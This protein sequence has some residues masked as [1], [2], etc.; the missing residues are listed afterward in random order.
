MLKTAIES[1]FIVPYNE[2]DQVKEMG[3]MKTYRYQ[4]HT[5]TSPCSAC[6][7]MTPAELIEGLHENGYQGCVMTNHFY[8]GNTGIDRGLPWKEF[9]GQYVKDY[10]K[11][12][13]YAQKYDLDILFGIEE[14]VGG[15]LEILCYGLTPQVLYDHPELQGADLKTWYD[16]MKEND[17]I[18]IQAHPF[19]E[20][21]Y[22]PKPQMLP[23]DCIDGIEVYNAAN[24]VKNNK[25]AEAFAG[26]HPKMLLISGADAHI[27]EDLF[28]GGI[29]T[30]K[31]IRSERELVEILRSGEYDLIKQYAGK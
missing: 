29:E 27:R 19:R 17:V 3:T 5:H 7:Y 8:R 24:T 2:N 18:C 30:G 15:S 28:D 20:R 11:C 6:A 16:V 26:Q 10:E 31:R 14:G 12:C 1:S 13:L 9:V 4:M 23:L 25:E 21:A 22:I